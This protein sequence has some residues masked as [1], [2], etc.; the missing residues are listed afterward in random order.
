MMLTFP[1]KPGLLSRPPLPESGQRHKALCEIWAS[2]TIQFCFALAKPFS[3]I[4]F[5]AFSRGAAEFPAKENEY[6][7]SHSDW[8]AIFLKNSL[9]GGAGFL[10]RAFRNQ[11]L[12]GDLTRSHPNSMG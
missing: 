7:E 11:H 10:L 2:R 8:Q 4:V 9:P 1:V 6:A 12:P 5:R 3:K